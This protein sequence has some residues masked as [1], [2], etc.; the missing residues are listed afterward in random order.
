MEE[1]NNKVK[2]ILDEISEL[3]QVKNKTLD[4]ELLDI[5]LKKIGIREGYD[6]DKFYNEPMLKVLLE[7]GLKRSY[8][9][10]VRK[11]KAQI[12]VASKILNNKKSTEEAQMMYDHIKKYSLEI[13]TTEK[14]LRSSLNEQQNQR[15]LYIDQL[16]SSY[17][18]II[19]EFLDGE[20]INNVFIYTDFILWL[21][22]YRILEWKSKCQDNEEYTMDYDGY[23]FCY[24]DMNLPK[25]KI[26]F[27]HLINSEI[28]EE[29]QSLIK[30]NDLDKFST[31]LSQDLLNYPL[32][33]EE[34]KLRK[35]EKAYKIIELKIMNPKSSWIENYS[36]VF[37]N[38]IE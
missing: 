8:M 31:S 29:L 19:H 12:I 36:N 26:D 28:N 10:D 6:K 22:I 30:Y 38:L 27:Y 7:R 23:E 3:P 25:D 1:I 24:P 34:R 13:C 15:L 14:E 32:L 21:Y 2:T 9:S 18:K 35:F 37:V 17:D 20:Y 5:I 33:S 16:R 11:F 4:N